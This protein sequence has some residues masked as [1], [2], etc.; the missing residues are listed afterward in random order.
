MFQSW[1]GK[2]REA[3]LAYRS[4]Q[5]EEASRLLCD[6]ELRQF[7]PAQKLLAKVAGQMATRGEQRMTR[8]E[9][10]A[11]WR[12][13]EAAALFGAEPARLTKVR[14]KMLA[15]MLSE[16]E[17]YVAAGDYRAALGRLDELE[18]RRATSQ[19]TR[20]WRQVAEKMAAAQRLARRGRFAEAEA[21]LS[22]A[23]PL[24]GG[25]KLLGEWLEEYRL[26]GRRLRELAAELH[27]CVASEDWHHALGHADAILELAPDDRAA[28]DARCR[29]WSAVGMKIAETTF[30]S[31]R[32]H[33][34]GS[35]MHDAAHHNSQP[36][37]ERFV[38]WVDEVGA[39]LVCQ[40]D[41]VSLG[42]PTS[43]AQVDIPLLADLSRVQSRIRRE[44]EGYLLEP[45]R[46]TR[47]NG[48]LVTELAPLKDGD[49]IE[50]GSSV[51]LRFRKPHAL[52]A[53]ARL[54]FVSRHR[55]QPSVDGVI[56]MAESCVLGPGAASHV[57]CPDWSRDVVL[58]RQAGTLC[59]RATDSFAV[60]GQDHQQR[61][62][63]GR[64]STVSGPDF[65]FTLEAV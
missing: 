19:D 32:P 63:I 53:S 37:G 28:R 15:Q 51:K 38:L 24:S 64:G 5:L 39:F 50:L 43:G 45:V 17:Q 44:G 47:L 48:A 57:V 62:E 59:C 1:R 49:L 11:G 33:P 60:D 54:E 58:Y 22:V 2:L 12:D 9:T 65:S 25:M 13:V 26:K 61:A 41:E 3:E 34:N 4:G 40:G 7:L 14:E 55:T 36:R 46:T 42:Q 52:S 21:E 18:R 35:P 31:S 23:M 20:R 56:L 10:L 6:A 16:V 30:P 8:G 29:A 27:T